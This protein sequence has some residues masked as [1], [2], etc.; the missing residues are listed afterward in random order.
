[1]D[2][3]PPSIREKVDREEIDRIDKSHTKINLPDRPTKITSSNTSC[4]NKTQ[5][6]FRCFNP[7][8]WSPFLCPYC[9]NRVFPDRMHFESDCCLKIADD[10]KKK[11][12]TKFLGNNN[13]NYGRMV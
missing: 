9:N 13:K 6:T 11:K 1:M 8:K 2:G 3:L 10:E 7:S 4:L 12:Q 5:Y